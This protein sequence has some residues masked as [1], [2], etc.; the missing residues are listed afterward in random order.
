MKQLDCKYRAKTPEIQRATVQ[1]IN[2][3]HYPV[4]LPQL[5]ITSTQPWSTYR[6]TLEK[7]R[8]FTEEFQEAKD[9]R[10]IIRP[11]KRKLAKISPDYK[12]EDPYWRYLLTTRSVNEEHNEFEEIYKRV[13]VDNWRLMKLKIVRQ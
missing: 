5:S 7:L 8:T 3:N 12:K 11:Q 4:K 13:E 10:I 1:L 9:N 2:S 6:N